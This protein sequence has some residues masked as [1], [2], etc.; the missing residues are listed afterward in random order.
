MHGVG[1]YSLMAR[2]RP[3]VPKLTVGSAVEVGATLAAS[4]AMALLIALG[5]SYLPD[6]P[7]TSPLHADVSAAPDTNVLQFCTVVAE[8]RRCIEEAS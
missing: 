2:S 5:G 7:P 8:G 1:W 6:L 3:A 4:A